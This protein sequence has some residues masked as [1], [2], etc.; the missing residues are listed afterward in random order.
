MRRF[1]VL[2]C[3]VMLFPASAVTMVMADV[4][5]RIQPGWE[6][7]PL[8]PGVQWWR[9][10]V[11]QNDL[12]QFFNDVFPQTPHV[13]TVTDGVYVVRGVG[14]NNT[15]AIVGETGWV[16]VDTTASPAQMQI[17]TTLLR[18]YYGTKTLQAI[19]YTGCA[20]YQIGGACVLASSAPTVWAEAD[21]FTALAEFSADPNTMPDRLKIFGTYLEAGS[22]G[23]LG[24]DEAFGVFP[25]LYPSVLVSTETSA[26]LGGVK[27]SL[28]PAT[29]V[30][31]AGLTVWLPDLGVIIA[32]DVWSPTFPD[33]GP[34]LG[35]GRIVP[36][37]VDCL[38]AVM[39]KEPDF[40]VPLRGPVLTGAD[41]TTRL[42]DFRNAMQEIYEATQAQ[43]DLSVTEADAA[44][45]IELTEP[46]SG[47]SYAQPFFGDITAAVHGIYHPGEWRSGC[48]PPELV[49][50]LTTER[51][52]QIAAAMTGDMDHMLSTALAA[53]L[54]ADDLDSAEAALLMAWMVYNEYPDNILAGRIYA[55]VLKKNGFMQRSNRLRNVFLSVSKSATDNLAEDTTDPTVTITAPLNGARYPVGEVPAATYSV[56]DDTDP[57]PQVTVEGWSEGA[58]RHTLVVTATDFA[59]NVG[60]ASVTYTVLGPAPT[61]ALLLLLL[62]EDPQ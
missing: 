60:M 18:P 17:A 8:K 50:S 62:S 56:D 3:A 44:A 24:P 33:I 38:N 14:M 39:A 29:A 12:A 27:F 7:D 47:N 45:G 40:L 51:R 49:K 30:S 5:G 52:A 34:L 42:T 31:S 6:D 41:V 35:R 58:G 9:D 36:D 25:Y 15:T 4:S 54:A 53:E 37:W 21:F 13:E 46:L 26:T 22:D 2:V 32:G 43:I 55:Q 48:E 16:L 10:G 23:R 20:Q 59:D 28:I 61:G 57:Y 11:N 19:I 1:L